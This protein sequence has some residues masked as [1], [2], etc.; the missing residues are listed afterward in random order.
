MRVSGQAQVRPLYARELRY[1]INK[2]VGGSYR[3]SGH[4][5]GI[6]RR[7]LARLAH[8]LV[9][10]PNGPFRLLWR[11]ELALM[12]G[13]RALRTGKLQ[14]V[15]FTETGGKWDPWDMHYTRVLT[16][17][18]VNTVLSVT[19]PKE[20]PHARPRH[21]WVNNIKTGLNEGRC[22]RGGWIKVFY[23]R[24]VACLCGHV[25]ESSIKGM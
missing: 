9:T 11:H 5:P 14:N 25:N 16:M 12:C 17:W 3:E 13:W 20:K 7:F 4:L 18:C 23:C 22:E 21:Q 8:N 2:R 15:N 19:N 1:P 10:T 24:A 6:E